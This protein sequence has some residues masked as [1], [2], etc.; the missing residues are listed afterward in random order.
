ML[1]ASVSVYVISYAPAQLPLFFNLVSSTPFRANWTFLVLLMTLSPGCVTEVVCRHSAP[2]F[3]HDA[4][5]RQLGSQSSP[6]RHLQSQ[7]PPSLPP[8]AV[9]RL[10]GSTDGSVGRASAA[11]CTGHCH[12]RR[13]STN[14]TSFQDIL[15]D[16]RGLQ[17]ETVSRN[18]RP[19]RGTDRCQVI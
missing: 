13:T 3:P 11:G 14:S 19:I 18:G 7:L 16:V 1:I 10:P 2:S 9:C 15:H 4:V 5:V 17:D 12:R 8:A 6:L